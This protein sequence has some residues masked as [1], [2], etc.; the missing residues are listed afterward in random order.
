MTMFDTMPRRITE[1]HNEESISLIP[2]I[3]LQVVLANGSISNISYLSQPDLYFALRGGGK[4]FGVVTRFD[5]ETFSQGPVW[6]GHNYYLLEDVPDRKKSMHIAC[7]FDW[8]PGWFAEKILTWAIQ[9][10]CRFGY[11]ST[12][13]ELVQAME[14]FAQ[15]GL[16]SSGDI[17]LSFAFVPTGR[18]WVACLNLL[19]TLPE[20][21]PPVF[22]G[23]EDLTHVYTTKRHT[24]LTGVMSE[25]DWMNAI[26]YR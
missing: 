4:N 19:S 18:I 11:C 8:T 16:G 25:I 24:N 15:T 14:L 5:L 22:K 20:P 21:D 7:P 3:C 17:I 12:A 1:S 23:F 10:A 9:T 6:G 13:S 26:G 2:S